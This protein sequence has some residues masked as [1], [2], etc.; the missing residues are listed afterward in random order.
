MGGNDSMLCKMAHFDVCDFEPSD[1]AVSNLN[2]FLVSNL[3]LGAKL[4]RIRLATVSFI[5]YVSH[6]INLISK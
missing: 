3:C 2:Y 5:A 1:S 4:L 6:S